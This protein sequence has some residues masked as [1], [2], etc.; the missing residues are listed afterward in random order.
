MNNKITIEISDKDVQKRLELKAR[1]AN[2]N[3]N[4]YIL[5]ILRASLGFDN[6]VSP[7]Q[8]SKNIE[9]L[10]GT[11]T[12]EEYQAFLKNTSSFQ[13]IDEQLWQ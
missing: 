12:D 8:T 1:K 3:L 2:V 6:Q 13:D 5:Q 11:W 10:A 9:K 4:T 7:N